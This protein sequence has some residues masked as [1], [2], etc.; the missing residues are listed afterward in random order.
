MFRGTTPTLYFKIKNV[1]DLSTIEDIWVTIKMKDKGQDRTIINK[2]YK[3][4]EVTIDKDENMISIDLTQ[5]ETL[6]FTAPEVR[7]QLKVLFDDEKV[8]ASPIF[9]IYVDSI[10]NSKIME[11]SNDVLDKEVPPN[12]Q[13]EL[14]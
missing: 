7:T 11:S 8:C 5:Q 13:P 6:L 14:L 2:T 9:T 10:L 12:G 3:K 4:G 1:E